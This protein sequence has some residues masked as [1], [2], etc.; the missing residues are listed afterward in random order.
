MSHVGQPGSA[1]AQQRSVWPEGQEEMFS[2]PSWYC[3]WRYCSWD[4]GEGFM[5]NLLRFNTEQRTILVSLSLCLKY[6]LDAFLAVLLVISWQGPSPAVNGW[7]RYQSCGMST[8]RSST[9]GQG[10]RLPCDCSLLSIAISLEWQPTEKALF[11]RKRESFSSCVF[12]VLPSWVSDN[13]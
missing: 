4:K 13:T 9:T 10:A 8:K 7:T 3:M 5:E 12:F 2:Y 6:A 11:N 1:V